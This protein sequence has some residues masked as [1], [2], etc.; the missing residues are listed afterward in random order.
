LPYKNTGTLRDGSSFA[1]IIQ[2]E[3]NESG[4]VFDGLDSDGQSVPIDIQFTPIVKGDEDI[5]YNFDP[6]PVTPSDSP[7]PPAAQL[8]L[9]RNVYW[10]LDTQNGLKFYRYGTPAGFEITE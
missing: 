10:S 1:L 7:H 4:Y 9:C 2:T 5:Y 6:N 3:R 8:W